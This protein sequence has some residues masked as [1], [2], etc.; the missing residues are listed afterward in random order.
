MSIGFDRDRN[1]RQ[2]EST[3]NKQKGKYLVRKY[4]KNVF[5]FAQHQLKAACGL[6]YILTLTRN[7][8]GAVLIKD[9]AINNG[10]Y[11]INSN[12]WYVPPYT[13]SLAQQAIFVQQIQSKTPTELQYPER[14]IFLKEVN[15]QS[16]WNFELRNQEGI[17]IPIWIF[18]IFKQS[19]RQHDQNLGND[20]FCRLPDTSAQCNIGTELYADS[21]IFLNYD[22]EDCSQGYGQIKE[23]FR[24]LTKDDTLQP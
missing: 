4:L 5:G 20:T 22:D 17:N 7:S 10:E 3:N 15:T 6:A 14:S 24:A 18:V 1:R 8:D 12:H 13:P 19:D 21:A 9:N 11:E 23:A 2:R 16:L